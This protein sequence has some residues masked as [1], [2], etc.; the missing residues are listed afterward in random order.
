MTASN[1][2]LVPPG[3]SPEQLFDL[4]APDVR[5]RGFLDEFHGEYLSPEVMIP[6]NASSG[7]PMSPVET[8]TQVPLPIVG[9]G[10]GAV[11][12]HHAHFYGRTYLEGSDGQKAVRHSR[13]QRVGQYVHTQYHRKFHGTAF[14]E[15]AQDEY[16]LTV[17]NC[18]GYLPSHGVKIR[19]KHITIGRLSI[20]EKKALRNPDVF[21]HE[22]GAAISKFLLDYAL[23]QDFN[24]MK[25]LHIEEFLALT[26]ERIKHSEQLQLRKLRL[27][28]RLTHKAIGI[29]VDTINPVYAE[30]K[31]SHMLRSGTPSSA[32]QVVRN[33]V[34]WKIPEYFERIEDKIATQFNV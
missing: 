3:G 30:A 26:P 12:R 33:Q 16:E 32:W 11:N 27:A 2:N 6:I 15:T 8:A 34:K 23:E 21:T 18:A 29:A 22:N 25:Q 10:R 28:E 31:K 20:E 19:K 9:A 5:A 7:K 17:L 1:A 24:E 13:L 14:P 4:P